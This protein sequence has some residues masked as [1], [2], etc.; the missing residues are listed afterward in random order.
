VPKKNK[1][2]SKKKAKEPRAAAKWEK[3]EERFRPYGIVLCF[4]LVNAIRQ[5]AGDTPLVM[6]FCDTTNG[7]MYFEFSDRIE[8][9]QV[10]EPTREAID[11]QGGDLQRSSSC[12]RPNREFGA[13]LMTG[14]RSR[15][16]STRRPCMFVL[17]PCR[18][19]P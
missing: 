7:L 2:K 15:T 8:R 10:D 12:P 4:G 16:S 18:T 1:K 6:V 9:Y 11:A 19:G 3:V 17:S 5:S 13:C 14:S